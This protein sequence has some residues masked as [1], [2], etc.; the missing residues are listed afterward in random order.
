[1][2]NLLLLFFT[3][4]F[5]PAILSQNLFE[6]SGQVIDSKSKLALSFSNIR[7][8]GSTSGTAANKDGQFKLKLKAGNYTLIAS[9]I[10]YVS[11]TLNVQLTENYPGIVFNLVE[12]KID[13]AE[14]V[15]T[16]GINPALEIIRK[17]ILKKK[18]REQKIHGYEFD[19]YTKGLIR[20]DEE[21]GG[22]RSS[23]SMG[24]GS[25][26]SS[27]FKIT[28]ILENKSK[29]FFK[30]PDSFKEI[31]L[32]RK[33]SANFPPSINTLTGGRLI[34]NFYDDDVNFFNRD[35]PGPI[36]DDALDYYDYFLEE[37]IG[38]DTTKVFKI[39]M[40]TLKPFDPGFEGYLFIANHSFQLAKVD[41]Q[42]NPAA[43]ISGL[44]DTVN[45]FQQFYDFDSLSMPIDYRLFIRAN[46][47]GLAKIGFEINTILYDYKINSELD[48]DIFSNAIITVLPDADKKDSLYWQQIQ[49]IPNTQEE[50]TAYQRIDSLKKLPRDFWNDFSILSTRVQFS[51]HF[52]V[53]APLS[54]YHFNPVEG[55]ALDFGFYLDD[56][57]E[58]RLST[59]LLLSYGFSDKKVKSDFSFRYFLGDYRT[60][61]L[62]FNAFNKLNILFD[63][64]DNYNDLTS[65]L[66]ALL[67]KYSFR[68]YYYSKGFS[69]GIWGEL[70]P[71]LQI[72]FQFENRHDFSAL[73]RSEFSFF[74][75]D[76]I[77]KINNL[78][79]NL[80]MNI[81][82]A[83]F[84][85]DPRN[86]V[87]DGL[88]RRRVTMGDSYFTLQGSF[89]YSDPGFLK[90]G[91]DFKKYD[92][93]FF[94]SINSF[95][96][97][98]L[99]LKLYGCYS[100]GNLPYQ[101]LYSLPGNFD[102][103]FKSFS[104]R[105]L[106]VT[107]VLSDRVLSLNLEYNIRDELFKIAGIPGLR[108]WG[109]QLTTFVNTFYSNPS[110]STKQN[111]LFKSKEYLLP[112]YEVG[113]SI[114]H[115]LVPIQA[116]FAW[117]LNH[118]DGNNFRAGLNAFVF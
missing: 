64:S 68:D 113:F 76:K 25:S 110:Q 62:R 89:S 105:T 23:I 29:G 13:L 6:V 28:G 3:F 9:Y 17:A 15:V 43:N 4:L 93:T 118:R 90:S 74:A 80:K 36:A 107:E 81:I 102:L 16:P 106:N 92:L 63:E 21:I 57:L 95:G 65:S 114:G 111:P 101:L 94:S 72:G 48:E 55:N 1:M 116:E 85:I 19:A 79:N 84:K 54:M 49:S 34:Q 11:D 117:K 69:F 70:A 60:T 47:L 14:I 83:S 87:E 75:R 115:V 88:Y 53:S 22:G 37:T 108:D 46:Y 44:F 7:V 66:L 42:L 27:E 59:N 30:K 100:D 26:D 96:S 58:E 32:A 77:Y 40:R 78:I 18:E 97:T 86:Y 61:T 82:K 33:Q 45:V 73:N 12:T 91:A 38:F 2:Q 52:S 50:E 39:F 56:L 8:A 112:F 104:F 20:T 24:I 51:D 41:F 67:S 31:I 99:D 10:G 5:C 98:K 71:V 35:I 109:I 103:A